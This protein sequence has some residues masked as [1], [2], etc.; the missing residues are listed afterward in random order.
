M[1]FFGLSVLVKCDTTNHEWGICEDCIGDVTCR[2]FIRQL[3]QNAFPSLNPCP[4]DPGEYSLNLGELDDGYYQC[5]E[6]STSFCIVSLKA[7]IE[8]RLS[9][10]KLSP[11]M[12][13]FVY[14]YVGQIK[15][16][17]HR[18]LWNKWIDDGILSLDTEKAQFNTMVSG[19]GGTGH[20]NQLIHAPF[21]H[22]GSPTAAKNSVNNFY[23][24]FESTLSVHEGFCGQYRVYGVSAVVNQT[25]DVYIK[26]CSCVFHEEEHVG[27]LVSI[28]DYCDLF[29]RVEFTLKFFGVN[30][31]T[32]CSVEGR[33]DLVCEKLRSNRFKIACL[34]D[35]LGIPENRNRSLK[36]V[37][38][39]MDNEKCLLRHVFKIPELE[40]ADMELRLTPHRNSYNPQVAE[41]M[42]QACLHTYCSNK[43]LHCQVWNPSTNQTLITSRPSSPRVYIKLDDLV[44]L[45]KALVVCRTPEQKNKQLLYEMVFDRILE[46]KFPRGIIQ[47][48]P[49][50]TTFNVL[51]SRMT[52]KAQT[53]VRDIKCFMLSKRLTVQPNGF[54][55]IP[56]AVMGKYLVKC[57]LY[58]CEWEFMLDTNRP[59]QDFQTPIKKMNSGPW[60]G[61]KGVRIITIVV[62]F[63]F[64]VFWYLSLVAILLIHYA[65]YDRR[66]ASAQQW[67][68]SV[69]L[70][71]TIPPEYPPNFLSTVT[72]GSDLIAPE[73]AHK[74]EEL[75]KSF[76][77]VLRLRKDIENSHHHTI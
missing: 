52:R 17:H 30:D 14:M 75:F 50:N 36:N 54:I 25:F 77:E 11:Q 41:V 39:R 70:N 45:Q 5:F 73:I 2:I 67:R 59:R 7:N 64:V 63:H 28:R 24:I 46:F 19:D 15:S 43:H 42:I 13:P 71:D 34:K 32:R 20:Y 6:T 23:E 3:Q 49:S 62:L 55:R 76:Q 9:A 29:T 40:Y 72:L 12:K 66:L 68:Q 51:G 74:V 38:L 1:V 33:Q 31:R 61:L 69:H 44:C 48:D 26:N 35:D 21:D 57:Q 8:L 4:N 22:A 47:L 27:K 10:H 58:D 18:Q 37:T 65:K 56:A 53:R 60:I 16:T